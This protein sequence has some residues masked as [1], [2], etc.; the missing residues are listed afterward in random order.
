MLLTPKWWAAI[1]RN[2]TNNVDAQVLD[3]LFKMLNSWAL[4]SGCWVFGYAPAEDLHNEVA[5]VV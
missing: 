5:L 4:I 1:H 3:F 2:D